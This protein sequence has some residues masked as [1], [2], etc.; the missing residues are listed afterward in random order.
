[1]VVIRLSRGGAKKAPFYNIVVKD[2]R[3]RRDGRFIERVGYFNPMA[4]GKE[5]RLTMDKE[6][7][8]HWI[9]NGAQLSDRVTYLLKSFIKQDESVLSAAPSRKEQKIAQQKTSEAAAKKKQ[10]ET[11]KA[12]TAEEEKPK[13]TTE[14]EKLA[15][16]TKPAETTAEEAK[17]KTN[18]A[19]EKKP[20]EKSSAE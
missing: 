15:E 4:C 5:I 8:D 17:P 14:A 3:N 19:E 6:R 7:I 13:E 16:E 18:T 2:K 1:M 11:K 9:S 12:E 10:A 20:A